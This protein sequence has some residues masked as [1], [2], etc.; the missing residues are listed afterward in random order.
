MR[1][2]GC[3]FS[4]PTPHGCEKDH[5]APQ[6]CQ[7]EKDAKE[8]WGWMGVHVSG[9]APSVEGHRLSRNILK[10]LKSSTYNMYFKSYLV[11]RV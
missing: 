9:L 6:R 4:S 3:L 8:K 2:P 10:V 7:K 5:I 11:L 1:L